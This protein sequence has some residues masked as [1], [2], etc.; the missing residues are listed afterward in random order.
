MTDLQIL[1]Q[2]LNGFHLETRELERAKELLNQL[3][4]QLQNY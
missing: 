2:L 1:N 4:N 3:L